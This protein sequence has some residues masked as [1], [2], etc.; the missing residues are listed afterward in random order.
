MKNKGILL[1]VSIIFIVTSVLQINDYVKAQETNTNI[2]V[3]ILGLDDVPKAGQIGESFNFNRYIEMWHHSGGYWSYN[4]IRIYDSDL[5]DKLLDESA[6]E[7]A[8]DEEITFEFELDSEL[9]SKL[10]KNE[11]IKV[12]CSTKLE[13]PVTGEYRPVTDIFHEVPDIQLKNNKIYFKGK[14]K[15]NFYTKDRITYS[16]Y[17]RRHTQCTN[18]TG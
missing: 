7:D 2:E 18:P 14:P 16:D 4:D 11:N 15:L 6:L 17:N 8:I 12:V 10:T 5:E 9:Y 13:N 1:M 3:L